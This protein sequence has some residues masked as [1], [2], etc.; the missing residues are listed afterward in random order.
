MKR[1]LIS[2]ILLASAVLL[3][4]TVANARVYEGHGSAPSIYDA[5]SALG[6]FNPTASAADCGLAG[7]VVRTGRSPIG[8]RGVQAVSIWTV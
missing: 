5:D 6:K 8:S 1:S 7:Q 2:S 4:A 3:G